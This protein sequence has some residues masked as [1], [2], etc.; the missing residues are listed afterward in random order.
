MHCFIMK[1]R[2]L[3]GDWFNF[4]MEDIPTR[5]TPTEFA[6]L[7]KPNTPRLLLNQILRG[8]ESTGLYEGDIIH[9]EDC[10]WLVCYERGFYAINAD[11]V[12]RHLYT[13]TEHKRV[14]TC[15]DT[16]FPITISLRSRHMFKYKD[17]T[18]RLEDIVGP[19]DASSIILRSCSDAVPCADIQQDCGVV[20]NKSR[21]YLGDRF[22]DGTIELYKGRIAVCNNDGYTDVTTGGRL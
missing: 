14:G 8:D 17:K 20:R 2:T 21:L 6:L 7:H 13:F 4:T 16:E 22:E 9:S 15:F 5:F 11:R 10:D 3:N 18:F 19:H 12:T 1:A